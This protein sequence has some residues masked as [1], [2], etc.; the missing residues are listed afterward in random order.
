MFIKYFSKFILW[1]I[2]WKI[3]IRVPDDKKYV[4]IIAP[5]TSN[6]DFIIGR[7]ANWACDQDLKFMIK[8]EAFTFFMGPILR[9]LGGVPID[10][11]RSIK[12]VDQMVNRFK[13]K[14]RF[15][16]AITP[17]GTRK[18]TTNWKTGFYRIATKAGI[19]VYLGY[20][21]YSKKHG[22]MVQRFDPTGNMEEDMKVIKAYYKDM[23]GYY[24]DQF[25]AE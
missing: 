19:P 7:L 16:L 13:E 11:S 3:D 2:G 12:V 14:E 22:G 20:L 6:R 17:E 25:T 1:V 24:K 8:K 9:M 10:R 4:V 18:K 15:V 23:Q 5:H 21:D